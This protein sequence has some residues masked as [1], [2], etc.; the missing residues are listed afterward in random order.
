[1][2]TSV[3][4]RVTLA[5]LV[6]CIAGGAAYVYWFLQGSSAKAVAREGGRGPQAQPVIAGT[7][8]QKAMPVRLTAIGTVQTV[9]SVAVRTR[10][11]SQ[12]TQ[13]FVRDGQ[14]VAAGDRLFALDSRQLEAQRQQAQA[15]L[16]RDQLQLGLAKRNLDRKSP[17]I[18][19]EASIDQARTNVQALQASVA[20]DDANLR[21]LSV[22][23]SYTAIT[24]PI[25][26]RLGTIA[27]KVGSNVKVSDPTP[28]VT[29]N[30]IR[31]VYVALSV[32]QTYLGRIQEAMARGPV[33]VRATL[34]G[35]T[36]PAQD[37]RLA[38]VENAVDSSTSTISV[39]AEF[40]NE[41]EH[42]WPGAY[43]N[44]DVTLRTEPHALVV[45]APAVQVSQQGTYVFVIKNDNTVESRP[46]SVDRTIGEESVIS[47]GL[48]LGERVVVSGQL[49]LVNGAQV[50]PKEIKPE[51]HQ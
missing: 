20:A 2:K 21:N 43:V 49:R 37:G 27:Y 5:V 13:V 15:M 3:F 44:V 40:P 34:P 12:I 19:S 26:G 4:R 10:L 39:K 9:N 29:I 17:S 31:P 50:E 1:L 33:A 48:S 45:P 30:Q 23:L 14:R 32:P 47:H 36:A 42:L 22:Q 24:A 35:S 41:Q 6:L 7:V 18:D 25:S 11:D 38:Y 46:V 16:Q 51:P 28:L 8:V